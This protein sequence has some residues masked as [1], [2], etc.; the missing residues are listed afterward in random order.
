MNNEF[1]TIALA[2]LEGF[3]LIISPCILPILPLLLSGSL[4]GGKR[5]PLGIITGFIATFALFTFFSRKLVQVSGID[6][7][8][9]RYISFG[10]LLLFGIIMLSSYLTE[11]FAQLTQRLANMTA[12]ATPNA[13]IQGGFSSGLVFGGLLGIVWTPCAGPILAAVIVQIVIQQTTWGSL[14]TILAFALGAA[15]PMLIIALL[16]RKILTHLNFFKKRSS[17]LRKILG[18]IIIASVVF[19][20]FSNSLT[21]PFSQNLPGSNVPF[22]A[23][24]KLVNGLKRPYPAPAIVGITAWINSKPL[25]LSQLQGKVVLIDFWAYSCIN[26]IRTIP[27]LNSWYDKYHDKGLVI[28][29]VHSPEFD[30]EGNVNN[31]KNATVKNAIHYPVALDNDF[32]TWRNYNNLYWPAHYLIDKKGNVVYEHFGEG[33]YNV[34]ENNIR[35]LLGLHP[36]K[37]SESAPVYSGPLTPETYLGYERE[38]EFYSPEPLI[39]DKVGKYSYPDRL[40][41]NAWALRGAW[42]FTGQKIVAAEANAALKIHF[43]A[44]KVYAVMGTTAKPIRV[45]LLLDGK[46]VVA[47][48]GK[49]VVHSYVEVTNHTLYALIASQHHMTGILELITDAP[50]LKLYTFTFG[51]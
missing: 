7:N 22:S 15:V 32:K 45:S 48:A 21:L 42:E 27:Y 17:V 51:D 1:I 47:E 19:M 38:D 12:I 2:F 16:G 26:C 41:E 8:V 36:S 43:Q 44:R 37:K 34:T 31:V 10:L 14:L 30:F 28:I 46:P 50:G 25:Q 33:D 40:P 49:D 6:L 13:A 23:Q 11:K 24:Q 18:I 39:K 35:F 5:R 9:I 4:E 3:A 29:G 20:M